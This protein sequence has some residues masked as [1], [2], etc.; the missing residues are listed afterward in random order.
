MIYV[1]T[2]TK[3]PAESHFAS[4]EFSTVFIPGDER[5]KSHPGHGYPDRHE[6]VVK[7]I[8]F[9]DNEE[10]QNYV[11]RKENPSYGTPDKNYM[12]V[13]IKPLKVTKKISVDIE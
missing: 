6:S 9:K 4:L 11:E 10:L 7:Y 8:V 5:S 1:D 12:V 13:E 2:K 3:A